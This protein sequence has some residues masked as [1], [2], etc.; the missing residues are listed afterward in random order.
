MGKQCGFLHGHLSGLGCEPETCRFD[1]EQR[2]W[3]TGGAPSALEFHVHSAL[4]CFFNLH[5][6][7]PVKS[8]FVLKSLWKEEDTATQKVVG[9]TDWSLTAC[10]VF[11]GS[12]CGSCDG[13][14]LL[15]SAGVGE[16]CPSPEGT[17]R[18]CSSSSPGTLEDWDVAVQK[19]ETRLA[20]VNEQRMKVTVTF[21]R[22]WDC[23]AP[24]PRGSLWVFCLCV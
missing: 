18:L 15:W 7:E 4:E 17:V 21:P 23:T 3:H 22:G 2:R 6:R 20:R 8:A 9:I 5:P 1:P 10:A 14:C 24:H 13:S 16:R 19:T 11:K 12:S